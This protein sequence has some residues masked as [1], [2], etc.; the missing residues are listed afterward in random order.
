MELN[1]V[2]ENV[3]AAVE[4]LHCRITI[5][6]TCKVMQQTEWQTVWKLKHS[7]CWKLIGLLVI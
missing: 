2:Q 7:S 3:N 6:G 4:R 5:T 1:T